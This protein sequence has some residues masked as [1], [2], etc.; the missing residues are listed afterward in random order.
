MANKGEWR[1]DGG[2]YEGAYNIVTGDFHEGDY[3][4]IAEDIFNKEDAEFIVN[5]RDKHRKKEI[6][7]T[8][9]GGGYCPSCEVKLYGKANY[10]GKCGQ[11]IGWKVYGGN[12]YDK[13]GGDSK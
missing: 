11:R 8:I 1:I 4:I 5:M 13:G 12:I 10:C 2:S 7:K 3:R 9:P 6:D